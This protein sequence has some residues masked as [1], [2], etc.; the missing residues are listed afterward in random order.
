M[1]LSQILANFTKGEADKLRKAMGKKQIAVLNKLKPQFIE[2]GQKNGHPKETLEKIW[3]D[4]EKFAS[5]AFN[6]SHATCY[7]FIAYQTAYLKAH[8]PAEF[9]AAVLSNN[10]SDIKKVT[11]Y[12]DEC[13]HSGLP[14]LGPDVNESYYKFA[15]NKQGAIRFGMGGIKG[16]GQGA[17]EAII[18]ERKKNGPFKS[19]FDFAKRI[20]LRAANKRVF[21]GLALAGGFDSFTSVHRAQYFVTDDKGKNF[22]DKAIKFGNRYQESLNSAQMSLFGGESESES[23]PEPDIPKC[24]EWTVMEKLSKEKE[25]VGI[26]ISGHPLDDY[27]NELRY[28]CN[29]HLGL[30]Q[31]Q[32][33]LLDKELSFGG[34]VTAVTHRISKNGKGWG[35]FTIEDYSD[36]FEF[37]IF[38]EE[39][40]RFKHFLV[41]NAFLHIRIRINK[42]WKEGDTRIQFLGIQMLQDVLDNLSK[43]LTLQFGIQ[44]VNQ[45]L[46]EKLA[47]LIKTYKGQ[48]ELN[49]LIY[50]LKEK[51]KLHMPSR[52]FKI[53]ITN[54]LLKELTKN[55]WHFT[56]K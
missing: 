40:L 6:K 44:E 4:W 54:D 39:Y 25:V 12:M 51:L 49:F 38:G 42:G 50:D 34:I 5:Y 23:L 2:N 45:E 29:G 16:V 17:V 19:I 56:V 11:F 27:K 1:R 26:Y 31:N 7:A 28:F 52:K 20:D 24:D 32:Q 9:M 46:I 22:I 21:E 8:Y 14:V 55:Q 53:A 36:S 35:A 18:D 10:M 43:K 33:K 15:V 47:G 37:R 41:P 13:K 30:L 3:K 48:K